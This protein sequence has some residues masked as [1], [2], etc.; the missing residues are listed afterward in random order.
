MHPRQ[1]L[2]A[3]VAA[4]LGCAGGFDAKRQAD[5][6]GVV[7]PLKPTGAPRAAEP[8]PPPPPELFAVVEEAFDVD[9]FG[10][11]P[12]VNLP[13]D[14]LLTTGTVRTDW[15]SGP[16]RISVRRHSA[17][18]RMRGSV[19]RFEREAAAPIAAAVKLPPSTSLVWDWQ[20]D[21][22]HGPQ[23]EAVVVRQPPILGVRDVASAVVEPYKTFHLDLDTN[24]DRE[25]EE[26][27]VR[28]TFTEEGA[29]RLEGFA[30][31]HPNY[32]LFHLAR[33]RVAGDDRARIGIKGVRVR[34]EW[35]TP[36]ETF[37]EADAYVAALEQARSTR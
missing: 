9:A 33:G 4:S 26:R 30:L 34:F 8:P 17:T 25:T 16:R 11:M 3:T 28:I 15:E 6:L 22:T 10:T 24:R 29:H 31:N 18:V 2:I 32:P 23:W 7:P 5:G 37:A 19:D 1:V 20:K 27:A 13:L 35:L 14:A 21:M 36:E 12:R